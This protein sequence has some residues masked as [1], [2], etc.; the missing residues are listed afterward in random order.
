MHRFFY[1]I[2]SF[3]LK[4][5]LLSTLFFVVTIAFFLI[6]ALQLK[7]SEN[8]SR[9]LPQ[10]SEKTEL[11]YV[12]EHLN[13]S[14]RIFLNIYLEDSLSSNPEKLMEYAKALH[15]K[16]LENNNDEILR[17]QLQIPNQAVEQVSDYV[18]RNI[19]FLLQEED[20]KNIEQKLDSA[21]FQK[22]F[23][24]KY[25]TLLGPASIFLK[26][27][28]IQDPMGI[29]LNTLQQLRS[30]QLDNSI[31]TV[32]NY[33]F[34]NDKKH[35]LFYIVPNQAASE[36]KKNA[37]LIHNIEIS[38]NE[39]KAHY[40]NSIKA[41]F[42]GA[43]VV[44]VG[45]AKQIKKDIMLTVS[46]AIIAVV[47]LIF[48]FYRSKRLYALIFL[49]AA[50]AVL[51]TMAILFI[52]NRELSAIALGMGSVLVGIS[53]D[54]VLHIFTHFQKTGSIQ[55]VL[56]DVSE[57]I[58]IS[59]TTTATAFFGLLIVSAPALQDMGIFAGM[60]II[61]SALYSLIFIPLFLHKPK[62][63]NSKKI[64]RNN[65]LIQGIQWL[66]TYPFHKKKYWVFS[67]LILSPIFYYFSQSVQF[68]GDMNAINFMD[69]KTITA[70]QHLNSI[71]QL[72]QRNI[73]I[74]SSSP[75]IQ[76]SLALAENLNKSLYP[77]QDSG[78][79]LKYTSLQ[80]ILPSEKLQKERL[81]LW[82]KFWS[83]EKIALLRKNLIEIEAKYHFK[84]NTFQALFYTI[85]K[86]YSKIS[87]EDIQLI[88][89]VFLEEFIQETPEKQ[90][91]ITQIK[92]KTE[93]KT[94]VHQILEKELSHE[95]LIIDKEYLT[96]QF[97]NDL[98]NDF[99]NLVF[100]TLLLVFLIIWLSF[101]RI[102]LAL[103]T[104]LPLL[105]SWVW[106]MGLMSILHIQ[107]NIVNIIITS[108][109]FGLGI[110]YSIF[111]TRGL[112]QK[113]KYGIEQS[114]S[115]KTSIIISAIT[116]I[117]G[118]GVLIFAQHPALKSMAAVTVIGLS[119][120]LL[121]SFTLQALLFNWL[122][123][124]KDYKKRLVPVT[125]LNILD[126]IIAILIFTTGSLFNTLAGFILVGLTLG[127]SKKAKLWFHH[128]IR[129]S[130][131]VMIF[132]MFNTRKNI[133]GWD[134]EK[135]KNPSVIISNHQSHIDIMLM[136]MLHPKIIIL[137][138]DWVQRNFFYGLIVKWANFYPIL[139][140]L[141]HHIDELK[142]QVDDGYSIM[143]FPE[144]TRSAT[145]KIGRF[146]KG[147][148]YLAEQLQLSILPI[149]LHGS[150]DCITKGEPYL[151]SGRIDICIGEKIL[152]DNVEYGHNYV[153]RSKK[154]RHW[155]QQ[156]F[157]K[158]KQEVVHPKY[159]RKRLELN[160]IY[161]G[162]ILEW[163]A[164][165]KMNFEDNYEFFHKAIAKD[166]KIID[167]GC[168]YGFMDYMLLLLSNQREIIGVDYDDNKIKVAQNCPAYLQFKPQQI[169]FEAA[170]LL[171]W[172]YQNADVYILAD[173]LHYMPFK[174]QKWVIEQAVAKLNSQGQIIIRDADTDLQK[175][176]KGTQFSEWQS[177]KLIGFNKTKD[178]SKELYFGSAQDRQ[179]LL[180]SLGLEVQR[181]DHTKLNSNVVI[182]GTKR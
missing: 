35:L 65:I 74:V 122:V 176:H 157:Q 55:Q 167:L 11:S 164:K 159:M 34:T 100:I 150:G 129:A 133:K 146:H 92:T 175:K 151:K 119:S 138:N 105:L 6:A 60:S 4:H 62:I 116:T 180:E 126:S 162:P 83:P 99:Q 32:N 134:Y 117:I 143:V 182:I 73:Y 88:R 153:E 124:I 86:P 1:A 132:I 21:L 33:L 3:I 49:P 26:K 23:E 109:I 160:Y 75:N 48:F 9:I 163:Y 12:L 30:F 13:F 10:S 84:N 46:I 25:K 52:L 50:L 59:A 156:E 165:I 166:A 102:E 155:Y 135:F 51:T 85:E 79:I 22:S 98:K 181:I 40:Q 121:L 142:S 144:G 110:D 54:Y 36:T 141:Q 76:H 5:K 91:V 66:T 145:G 31:S 123:Y 104:Y 15:E 41:E 147:A 101:G 78:L 118:V 154:F 179:E 44:A 56:K 19:P 127:R 16:L 82:I 178:H 149:V 125:A 67:I 71:T 173:V 90:M 139:D 70:E 152:T 114:K 18:W 39:L 72:S 137:T 45:N 58:I 37:Q 53:I 43:P 94:T 17:I 148:F 177:T 131:W 136:L 95:S 29:S 107:F 57:P 140:Q 111:I 69:E 113:Y 64:V 170:D 63:Q 89:K 120:A 130:S 128:I 27:M 14:E 24:K 8:A 168:G 2:R 97:V 61:F 47:L 169:L 42:F 171:Q 20:Y 38:I 28:I 172:N 7:L 96:N 158:L 68:Q 80:S 174:D 112:T 115:Y 93:N 108:F 77:L 87:N 81:A 106:T 161:K 103:I